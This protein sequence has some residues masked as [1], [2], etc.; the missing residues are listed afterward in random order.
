V[1][2]PQDGASRSNIK[3]EIQFRYYEYDP[4]CAE[5]NYWNGTACIP[6]YDL[7]CSSLTEQY[8][9]LTGN[10]NT[11]VTYN[12]TNCVARSI[13]YEVKEQVEYIYINVTSNETVTEVVD[14]TFEEMF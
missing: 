8:R 3:A 4:E 2:R 14:R 1:L 13:N 6:D 12:G 7:Y 5:F 9:E 11:T 10:E